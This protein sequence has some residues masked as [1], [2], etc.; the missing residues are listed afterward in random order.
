MLPNLPL[1]INN[2]QIR[3][4]DTVVFGSAGSMTLRK[5]TVTKINPQTVN[6]SHGIYQNG[7]YS[8]TDKSRRAFRDVVVIPQ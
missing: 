4:G 7:S 8:D 5:G 3:E 1:D 2:T 6:I